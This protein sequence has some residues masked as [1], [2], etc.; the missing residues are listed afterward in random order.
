[1][2]INELLP[3]TPLTAQMFST[4]LSQFVMHIHEF[5]VSVIGHSAY[6]CLCTEPHWFNFDDVERILVRT[7]AGTVWSSAT[8]EMQRRPQVCSSVFV[9]FILNCSM[10]SSTKSVIISMIILHC[11]CLHVGHCFNLDEFLK[12]IIF[13]GNFFTIIS[14]RL[15][16][17]QVFFYPGQFCFLVCKHC[18][19]CHQILCSCYN[20]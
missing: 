17:Q 2:W 9:S 4:F 1:M 16:L 3:G 11:S 7:K 13:E 12:S 10:M 15:W 8:D 19:Q 6:D 14:V 18:I 20:C 5:P